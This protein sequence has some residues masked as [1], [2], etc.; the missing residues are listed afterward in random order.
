MLVVGGFCGGRLS[1]EIGT[2]YIW[3][4]TDDVP[5]NAGWIL[6]GGFIILSGM[7]KK[8]KE[9]TIT[10]EQLQ[11]AYRYADKLGVYKDEFTE[12]V[13]LVNDVV[14]KGFN[15]DPKLFNRL[16]D[17]I[18]FVISTPPVFMWMRL[19]GIMGRILR[20]VHHATPALLL[21][22]RWIH[23]TV[24]NVIEDRVVEWVNATNKAIENQYNA[25]LKNMILESVF[26]TALVGIYYF[27]PAFNIRA[28]AF[29]FM[30]VQIGRGWFYSYVATASFLRNIEFFKVT[31]FRA[32]YRDTGD[33]REAF[34]MDAEN[35]YMYHY[36]KMMDKHTRRLHKVTTFLRLS[37]SNKE[38]FEHIYELV[39]ASF[40][41]F[42]QRRAMMLGIFIVFYSA[43]IFF[44]RYFAINMHS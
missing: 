25:L 44:I 43:I 4:P 31:R 41:V 26:F 12:I 35:F 36:R 32:Y 15:M 9:K 14:M 20:F 23:R 22:R 11:K 21:S 29:V 3:N 6:G 30:G 27:Y 34:K 40:R 7:K 17:V 19:P 2:A 8:K 28:V 38:I 16:V 37:P 10:Q 13:D 1:N 33:F 18:L 42:I 39:I 5:A 24:G